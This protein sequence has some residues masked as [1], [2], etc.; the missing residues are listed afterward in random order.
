[1]YT[2][3]VFLYTCLALCS[4]G[5][6]AVQSAVISSGTISPTS[7]S[8]HRQPETLWSLRRTATTVPVV[9]SGESW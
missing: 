1:M 8:T 9:A 4:F 7:L 2:I 5:V 6:H 3:R